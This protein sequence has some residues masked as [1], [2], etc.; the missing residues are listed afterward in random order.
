VTIMIGIEQFRATVG[1]FNLAK[2]L[3]NC[4][5]FTDS[6]N[7]S[8]F[9]HPA[10]ASA[11]AFDVL[12]IW[13]CIF[14]LATIIWSAKGNFACAVF[15][16]F[17]SDFENGLVSCATT[18]AIGS[19]SEVSHEMAA[20]PVG[21]TAVSTL[22]Q[23]EVV[24]C[25]AVFAL[26][27]RRL[28][29]SNDVEENPGP[30]DVINNEMQVGNAAGL[31]GAAEILGAIQQLT[32]AVGR[33]ENAQTVLQSQQAESTMTLQDKLSLVEKNI[34]EKLEKLEQ[35][36]Q[37]LSDDIAAM[38][39]KMEVMEE[40]NMCL[41]GSM[42]NLERKLDYLENQSRRCNLLFHGIPR[43]MNETWKDC[44][45]SV[46]K[47]IK[48]D[49][50]VSQNIIIERAH[51]VGSAI[52]VKLFSFKDKVLLQ[53]SAK[54]LASSNSG[55]SVREDFSQTVRVKR[56]GLVQMMKALRAD[57]KRAKLSFDRLLSDE[58]TFTYDVV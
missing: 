36:N 53:Q 40:E 9:D 57:G 47:I 33:I 16:P 26:A 34:H 35:E 2:R 51:R 20:A 25:V 29:L 21:L 6:D 42:S 39:T 56:S 19:R 37:M 1:L 38:Q 31:A 30:E 58:G 10:T 48:E 45:D 52:I 43:K 5:G 8:E 44:E 13:A 28:R 54:N 11:D 46:Q 55:V 4:A 24:L 22:M 15:A 41:R 50:K 18:V 3:P 23:C 14:L 7:G 49:M 12:A 27:V 17:S 32:A